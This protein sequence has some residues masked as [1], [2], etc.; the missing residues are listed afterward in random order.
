V[1]NATMNH[2]PPFKPNTHF[3]YGSFRS[4]ASPVGWYGAARGAC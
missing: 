2:S 4:L 3:E 1:T